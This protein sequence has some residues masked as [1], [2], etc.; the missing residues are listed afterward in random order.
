M[1]KI[2]FEEKFDVAKGAWRLDLGRSNIIYERMRTAIAHLNHDMAKQENSDASATP[3]REM[4]YHGTHLRD[5]ILRSFSPKA[6][7]NPEHMQE[8]DDVD[9]VSHDLL[10]HS[11]R[12]T[13]DHGGAFKDDMRIQSWA[14]RYSALNPVRVEGDPVLEGMNATQIRAAAMMIGE[15]VSLVQGVSDMALLS[16]LMS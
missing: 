6:A 1:L 7:S 3:N 2:S 5:V 14:R 16:L 9:Y 4:I 11:S 13:G 15:R 8:A 10:E 12:K